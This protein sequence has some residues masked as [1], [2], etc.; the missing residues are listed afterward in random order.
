MTNPIIER[1][2]LLL[3]RMEALEERGTKGEWTACVDG[4]YAPTEGDCRHC[5]YESQI[6]VPLEPADRFL[7]AFAHNH[8]KTE[9]VMVRGLLDLLNYGVHM[10]DGTT[11]TCGYK[12]ALEDSL[13]RWADS[14]E[15]E[16]G[17]VGA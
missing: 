16:L 1:C 3:K 12:S 4:V 14:T 6:C 5:S 8:S 2:E 13:T 10:T 11:L 17:K 15:A 9:R 7:I